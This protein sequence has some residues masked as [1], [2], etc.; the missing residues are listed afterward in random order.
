[1]LVSRKSL[2]ETLPDKSGGKYSVEFHKES[3]FDGG[4]RDTYFSGFSLQDKQVVFVD[5]DTGFEPRDSSDKHVQYEDVA[6]M[7]EHIS[8]DSVIS[9]FQDPSHKNVLNYFAGVQERITFG[10]TTAIHWKSQYPVMFVAIC[11]SQ[12]MLDRVVSA[13]KEYAARI[14]KVEVIT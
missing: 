12:D 8:P 1:M 2:L 3:Y 10:D 4:R 14:E 7:L 6:Q 11:K 13:N 9:V 5:P